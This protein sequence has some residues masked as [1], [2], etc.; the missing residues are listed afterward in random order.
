M[1][2]P[3]QPP[4]T[5]TPTSSEGVVDQGTPELRQHHTVAI[6]PT[7]IFGGRARLR[8]TDQR[9][10]DLMFEKGHLGDPGDREKAKE[11]WDT[12]N[13][14]LRLSYSS[15]LLGSV[16]SQIGKM[17]RV[18]SSQNEKV[19]KVDAAFRLRRVLRGTIDRVG[20]DGVNLMMMV[21]VQDVPLSRAKRIVGMRWE[22]ALAL[23]R[24]SLDALGEEI[25]ARRR[26]NE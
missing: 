8:V 22:N 20:A 12:A 9:R 10:I 11:R 18:D 21:V 13:A 3:N 4:L 14:L 6:E 26:Q 16:E 19:T 25:Q 24:T 7:S 1:S 5:T 17:V 2:L 23:L 15:G